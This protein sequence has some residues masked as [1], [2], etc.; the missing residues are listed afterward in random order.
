MES[1][2][3][4]ELGIDVRRFTSFGVIKVFSCDCFMALDFEAY[5]Q[6]FLRRV[7]RWP[8][9]LPADTQSPTHGRRS[10]SA[11]STSPASTSTPAGETF[12]ISDR[13]DA[14][15]G[16]APPSTEPVLSTSITQMEAT[17]AL[18]RTSVAEKALEQFRFQTLPRT[19]PN[20]TMQQPHLSPENHERR[21][22]RRGRVIS[23]TRRHSAYQHP[24]NYATPT[25]S[26]G[27]HRNPSDV[28]S[29]LSTRPRPRS[30]SAPQAHSIISQGPPGAANIPPP[31]DLLPLLDG[32]HHTDE[33]CTRFEVGWPQLQQW[34]VIVG[35]GKGDGDFGRV[36]IIYR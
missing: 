2:N 13:H 26:V 30:P 29:T 3:V 36:S 31:P 24:T 1:Y 7:H 12:R 5:F 8:I 35:G 25:S 20:P 18:N 17:R 32:D 10:S 4:H 23:E 22:E 21:P 16:V 34:L 11:L 19:G 15:A 28:Q 27:L 33:L 14:S 9:L 6:G